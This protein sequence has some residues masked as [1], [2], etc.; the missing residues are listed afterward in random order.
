MRHKL[1]GQ[2]SGLGRFWLSHP[3]RLWITHFSVNIDR[4]GVTKGLSRFPS[5]CYT[6]R[7]KMA[8]A[9]ERVYVGRMKQKGRW[10][11]VT[12]GL[13]LIHHSECFLSAPG[14]TGSMDTSV[15]SKSKL[16][17]P[18]AILTV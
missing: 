17:E 3:S 8:H 7:E 12:K 4:L 1:K 11:Q 6:R 14:H 16:L 10:A 15:N 5:K 9:G 2:D 18:A 13:E